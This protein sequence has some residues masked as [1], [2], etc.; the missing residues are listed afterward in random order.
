MLPTRYSDKLIV[1]INQIRGT[2]A[3]AQVASRAVQAY[4]LDLSDIF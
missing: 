1:L 3:A 4:T 2:P